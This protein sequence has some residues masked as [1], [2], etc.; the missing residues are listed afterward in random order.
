MQKQNTM[1]STPGVRT[2]TGTLIM[3]RM[4]RTI[5]IASLAATG[6]LMTENRL[7]SMIGIE[8]AM[9]MMKAS[10]RTQGQILMDRRLTG[11]MRVR[12]HS[13]SARQL[14]MKKGARCLQSKAM[15]TPSTTAAT[16]AAR[17]PGKAIFTL[18]PQITPLISSF[19]AATG[20][21][22][23]E[24]NPQA[25]KLWKIR[26]MGAIAHALLPTSFKRDLLM[27]SRLSFWT[28]VV[29]MKL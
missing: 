11:Q 18:V 21:S 16:T 12:L 8:E 20:S 26:T 27:E 14:G 6:S 1:V 5:Y 9:C 3:S 15:L 10:Q 23:T 13:I 17:V 28:V 22:I 24:I 29:R 4:T 25:I 2:G 19:T 7:G